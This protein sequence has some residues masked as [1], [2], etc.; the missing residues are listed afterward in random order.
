MELSSKTWYAEFFRLTRHFEYS[1]YGQFDV[2]E[3]TYRVIANEFNQF[4]KKL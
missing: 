3:D 1:W 4:E 2:V